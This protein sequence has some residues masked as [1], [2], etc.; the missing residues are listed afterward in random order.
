MFNV[1]DSSIESCQTTSLVNSYIADVKTGLADIEI[2]TPAILQLPPGSYQLLPRQTLQCS[3]ATPP[4]I[5][6][7]GQS[8]MWN[9]NFHD[10]VLS[11]MN[12]PGTLI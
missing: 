7:I 9:E 8:H 6:I 12:F 3:N 11:V 10:I 5:K 4:I 2:T 1:S